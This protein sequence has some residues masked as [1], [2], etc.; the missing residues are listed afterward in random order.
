MFGNDWLIYIFQNRLM[1]WRCRTELPPERGDHQSGEQSDHIP[2]GSRGVEWLRARQFHWYSD[3]EVHRLEVVPV[4]PR[5]LVVHCGQSLRLAGNHGNAVEER[6]CVAFVS[7]ESI[8]SLG[9]PC[10]VDC[11]HIHPFIGVAIFL[12]SL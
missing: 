8:L 3:N 7:S 5:A 12:L 1:T 6:Y 11:L 2:D 10:V 9:A 4:D